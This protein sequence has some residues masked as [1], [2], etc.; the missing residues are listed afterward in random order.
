MNINFST[1]K[2]YKELKSS[3]PTSTA[4]KRKIWAT[5]II[6]KNIDIKYLSKLLMCEQKIAIR[7]LWLLSE[8]GTINPNKLLIELPFL[9][10]LC[11]DLN[12]VYKKAFANYWLIVGV[13]MENEGQAIDLLFQ[14]LLSADTNV[15]IKSRSI[16]VLFKLTKKYP[17][18]KNELKI[19]LQD[20]M[21][22]HSHDFKK[23]ASKILIEMER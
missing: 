2:F 14:W 21:D 3:L 23:R 16:L 8:L 7:F 15:T 12:P 5:A 13:P 20:Q 4:E 9:L 10:D 1:P 6:E 17:E 11:D 22:K 18:L 19:C